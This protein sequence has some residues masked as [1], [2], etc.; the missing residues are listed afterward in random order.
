M[1]TTKKLGVW[2]DHSM[3]HLM[4][5]TTDHIE[6]RIIE[7]TFTYQDKENSLK[8]GESQ[9]HIKEQHKQSEY[10]KKLGDVIRNYEE[11]ILFGPT[12]AKTELFNIVKADPLFG[13]IN[14][15]TKQTDKMSENQQTAFVKDYFLK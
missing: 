3:A 6:S 9:M 1:S 13:K 8:K 10:Y 2:M 4:D 11:V 7:S 14:I 12:D 5:C 15:K